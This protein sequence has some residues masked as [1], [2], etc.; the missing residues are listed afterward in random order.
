MWLGLERHLAAVFLIARADAVLVGAD[1]LLA[2]GTLVNKAG[3]YLLALAAKDQNVP[4]WVC[5][6]SFKCTNTP[7]DAFALEE[8]SGSELGP[9]PVPYCFMIAGSMARDEQLLLTD[10]DNALVL[11]DSFDPEQHDAY[12]AELAQF[13]SN[14]L[15]ACGYAYC[16]GGIMASNPKWRQPLKVWRGYFTRWIEQP[17]PETLLNSSIFFDLDGVYGKTALVENL[18][19]LLA[20][21][22]SGTPAFLAA[23]ARNALNR[24]PPLGFFRT[25]VMETDGRQKNIINL[26]GRGTAPLTDLIRVHALACGSKAQNS[27]ERLDAIA[28]TKLLPK[29]ALDHLRYAFEFLSLVRIR[30]QARE[31][32]AGNPPDN[33]V[34]PEQFSSSERHHLKEAFQVVSNAQKFLRFRYPAQPLTRPQ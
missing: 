22:A 28:A 31:V 32:E 29:E 17:N 6:E 21:K 11:D 18:K 25:F 23:L 15:A 9:P 33:Y 13:V 20:E 27:L 4:F 1:A 19:E 24:T 26:K 10:Q 30:H 5:A 8:R 12:F 16:K 7:A 2:D 3:T 14:G 34:E